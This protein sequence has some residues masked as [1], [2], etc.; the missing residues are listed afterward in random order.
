MEAAIYL[1]DDASLSKWATL[2]DQT[3]DAVMSSD[4]KTGSQLGHLFR[5]LG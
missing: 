4:K 2:Y 3:A 1:E 5:D